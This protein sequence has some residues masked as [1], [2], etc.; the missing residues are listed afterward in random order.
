MPIVILGISLVIVAE[1]VS[2]IDNVNTVRANV[3]KLADA[4]IAAK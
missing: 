3:I 4:M 2:F 1:L